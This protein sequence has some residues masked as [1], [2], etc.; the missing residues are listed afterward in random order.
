MLGLGH[1]HGL[2]HWNPKTVG[3]CLSI[4]DV[5]CEIQLR[6]AAIKLNRWG[7]ATGLGNVALTNCWKLPVLCECLANGRTILTMFTQYLMHIID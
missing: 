3:D 6:P 2:G 4:R 7:G 5:V 1:G